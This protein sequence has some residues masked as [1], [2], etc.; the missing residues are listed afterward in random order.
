MK[1]SALE[2]WVKC[3]NFN[4]EHYTKCRLHNVIS[5]YS[6][7]K[8]CLFLQETGVYIYICVVSF[9]KKNYL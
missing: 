6:Q 1:Q 5:L 2:E 8:I 7:S 4:S 9:K 3:Y